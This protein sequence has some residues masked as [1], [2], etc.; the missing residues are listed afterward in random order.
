MT[1]VD[2]LNVLQRAEDT[3]TQNRKLR[4]E[5]AY[6]VNVLIED[7][8]VAELERT[9]IDDIRHHLPN[10]IRV[11]IPDHIAR[12]PDVSKVRILISRIRI[13][14]AAG[15]MPVREVVAPNELGAAAE[16][17][18]LVVRERVL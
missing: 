12:S 15:T 4:Q 11:S 16:Q 1:C 13:G 5:D 7:D 6:E 14:W 2:L 18:R 9:D 17:V 8:V 3:V 10:G